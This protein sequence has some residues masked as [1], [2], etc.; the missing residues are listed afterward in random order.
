MTTEIGGGMRSTLL[1]WL[2][3]SLTLAGLMFAAMGSTAATAHP[4]GNH[5]HPH[6]HH[7]CD[8]WHHH[9]CDDWDW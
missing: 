8:H 2:A 6:H 7:H 1:R 3:L 5:H 4:N 9:H